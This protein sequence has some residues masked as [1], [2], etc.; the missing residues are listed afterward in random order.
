MTARPTSVEPAAQ[1][2]PCQVHGVAPSGSRFVVDIAVVTSRERDREQLGLSLD[3]HTDVV[4]GSAGGLHPGAKGP[5]RV[6][7]VGSH[8]EGIGSRQAETYERGRRTVTITR[9]T[10]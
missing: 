6:V 10:A 1:H 2:H 9:E 7:A 4:C 3:V 8:A 5:G